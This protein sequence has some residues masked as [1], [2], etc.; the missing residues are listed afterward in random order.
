MPTSVN[1]MAAMFENLALKQVETKPQIKRGVKPALKPKPTVNRLRLDTEVKKDISTPESA[2]TKESP[3][4][5]KKVE[6]KVQ[7]EN[8]SDLLKQRITA[9]ELEFGVSLVA[10][11]PVEPVKK[12]SPNPVK[13]VEPKPVKKESPKPAKRV[14]P[15]P[16]KKESPKPVKKESPK[17]VKKELP[18]PVKKESP[19]PVKKESP[20]PVK[21]ESPK[22]VKKVEPKVFFD[23][24]LED[25]L[26][27]TVIDRSSGSPNLIGFVVAHVPGKNGHDGFVLNTG[28]YIKRC[29]FESGMFIISNKMVKE[30]VLIP[31]PLI[32]PKSAALDDIMSHVRYCSSMES[33]TQGIHKCCRFGSGCKRDS[34]RFFHGPCPWNVMGIQCM[35]KKCNCLHFDFKGAFGL[36]QEV[37]PVPN[38]KKVKHIPKKK[39]LVV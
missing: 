28:Q 33:F 1:A 27:A 12:E 20:K 4:P 38:A 16:V 30:H 3:N 7:A 6:P 19:K 39:D 34:C 2:G 36:T 14:V 5:V 9:L 17:P 24:K 31:Q 21:K 35:N 26:T 37:L 11:P 32:N 23:C 22:H 25:F 15:K 8:N 13:K 18:K 10:K 29:D